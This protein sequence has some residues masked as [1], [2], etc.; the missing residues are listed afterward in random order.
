MKSEEDKSCEVFVDHYRHDLKVVDSL[1]C[2]QDVIRVTFVPTHSFSCFGILDKEEDGIHYSS[3]D[4]ESLHDRQLC[5]NDVF[6]VSANET[7]LQSLHQRNIWK[8]VDE[9]IDRQIE[10]VS[11]GHDDGLPVMFSKVDKNDNQ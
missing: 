5:L 1:H 8:N 2:I 9:D 10:E 6:E 4:D 11:L 7:V 3:W